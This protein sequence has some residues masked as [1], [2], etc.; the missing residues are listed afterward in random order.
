M[1]YLARGTECNQTEPESHVK[2]LELLIQLCQFAI[3][4]HVA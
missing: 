2:G 3:S 4:L 1:S